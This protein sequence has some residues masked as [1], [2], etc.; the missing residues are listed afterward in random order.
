MNGVVAGDP[1]AG[2]FTS[3]D[4]SDESNN[5]DDDEGWD[6]LFWCSECCNE[7]GLRGD[8]TFVEIDELELHGVDETVIF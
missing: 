4:D 3:D 2:W 5:N 1:L 6:G 8:D 7:I